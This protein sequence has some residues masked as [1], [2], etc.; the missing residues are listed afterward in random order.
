MSIYLIAFVAL[1]YCGIG[2]DYAIQ[3][4]VGFAMTWYAYAVANV[5]LIIAA[6]T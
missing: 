6:R 4:R 3:G 1:L 2:T 5:G